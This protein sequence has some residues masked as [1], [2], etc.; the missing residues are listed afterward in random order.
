MLDYLIE[1][2]TDIDLD[3]GFAQ[4]FLQELLQ[5]S[6]SD[7]IPDR[8]DLGEPLKKTFSESGLN[9]AI[10]IWNDY[11][12]GLMIER[13]KTPKYLMDVHW[14][15][16][17]GADTRPFP[18]GCI[19]WMSSKAKENDVLSFFRLLISHFKPAFAYITNEDDTKNKHFIQYKSGNDIVEEYIGLDV[20][21]T[22]PGLFWRTYFGP[23]ALKKLGVSDF[24]M[25]YQNV[26]T[27][28]E[29]LLLETYPDYAD[30]G[31]EKGLIVEA[32]VKNILGEKFFFDKSSFTLA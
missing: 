16:E 18:W 14:R 13:K 20:G 11:G 9:N 7:L 15:R 30:C 32:S 1:L 31:T 4:P 10:K 3:R 2:K 6:I 27:L 12:M 23:F 17:Q 5:F 19:V 29:G 26:I 8:Y 22:L 21:D 24:S 25:L 28:Q